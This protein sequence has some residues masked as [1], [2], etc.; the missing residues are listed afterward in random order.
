MIKLRQLLYE[1]L[2]EVSMDDLKKQFVNSGKLTIEDFENIVKASNNKSSYATW[3]TKK[4]VDKVIK[5]EDV[6]KYKKYLE[7]FDNNKREFIEKDI[8]QIKT[9]KEVQDFVTKA[10]E[11]EERLSKAG[12]STK[13]ATSNLVSSEGIKQLAEVGIELLGTID[14]YQCF[15]IPQDLSGDKKAWRVY[16]KW[17]AR[18]TGREEGK[19][20]R[21]CTMADQENFDYYLH[22][23]DLYVFFNM[24]DKKSPY[25][26]SYKSGQFMDKN[27]NPII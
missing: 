20:I 8:N 23:E 25:Q 13:E 15:K 10:I 22:I 12:L 4:V 19:G 11:V 16:R 21:L 2:T 3:L 6:Y 17:L 26:F 14:G 18:C 27:N 9:K 5:A 1:I 24:S 7:I